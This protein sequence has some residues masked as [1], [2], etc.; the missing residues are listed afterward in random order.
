MKITKILPIAIIAVLP[1]TANADYDYDY[2]GLA[3]DTVSG[4]G[5]VVFT[6]EEHPYELLEISNAD[7]GHI[8]TTAYV[9]GAYNDIL[10]IEN[11]YINDFFEFYDDTREKFDKLQSNRVKIYT[12]WD[13]D[14]DAATTLVPFATAQ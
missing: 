4:D 1:F 9:K 3:T 7:E 2:I 5:T 10:A 14:T 12:T 8:A 13:N 6:I 11:R